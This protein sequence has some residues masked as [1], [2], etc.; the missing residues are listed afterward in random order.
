MQEGNL[1][2]NVETP[3][4]C[5]LQAPCVWYASREMRNVNVKFLKHEEMQ[6]LEYVYVSHAKK[7]MTRNKNFLAISIDEAAKI[8][9]YAN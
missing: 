2:I 5:T 8:A 7:R 3:V 1:F 4:S 6:C 9:N